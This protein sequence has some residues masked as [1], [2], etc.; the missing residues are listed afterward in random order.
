[1]A[2]AEVGL[3][4]VLKAAGAADLTGLPLAGTIDL[5]RNA[6]LF[7]GIDS[8]PAHV[9]NALSTP[10][11]V[12]MGKDPRYERRMPYSGGLADG[13]G[14]VVIEHSGPSG[15]LPPERVI[16]AVRAVLA[17]RTMPAEAATP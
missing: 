15:E 5:I 8:G 11:V 9:A 13:F 3:V 4:P 14:G 2:V 12:I 17:K 6:A 1:M 16:E 10:A 7:I